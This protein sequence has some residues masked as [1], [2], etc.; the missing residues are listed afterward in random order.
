[1]EI[2]AVGQ[3]LLGQIA[4]LAQA[5]CLASQAGKSGSSFAESANQSWSRLA[6]RMRLIASG[7]EGFGSGCRAIQASRAASMSG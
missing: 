2:G 7:F 4:R 3:L 5:A 1:M 6:R